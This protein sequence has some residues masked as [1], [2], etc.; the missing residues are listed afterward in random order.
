MKFDHR[1]LKFLL[2]RNSCGHK[3]VKQST[4]YCDVRPAHLEQFIAVI[5]IWWSG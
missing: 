3:E 5:I 2:W 4:I 1:R